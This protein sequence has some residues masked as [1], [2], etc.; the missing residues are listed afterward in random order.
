ML[1]KRI[2]DPRL[3]SDVT[4]P[5]P[6][7][8]LLSK[9]LRFFDDGPRNRWH[10]GVD[11]ELEAGQEWIAWGASQLNPGLLS[12]SLMSKAKSPLLAPL[13][14]SILWN[15]HNVGSSRELGLSAEAALGSAA[16]VGMFG[17][18]VGR[19]LAARHGP[20]KTS[21]ASV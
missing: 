15:L 18:W 11:A 10:R 21:G 12:Q 9:A 17:V 19:R 6:T 3:F 16:P 20:K 8:V 13:K 2:S 5:R 1:D 7:G 14:T 4:L